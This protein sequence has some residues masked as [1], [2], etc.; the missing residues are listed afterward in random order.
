MKLNKF[1]IFSI[2]LVALAILTQA[3]NSN[4]QQNT[5]DSTLS[6]HSTSQDSSASDTTNNSKN[7]NPVNQFLQQAA[8]GGL[9]EIAMGEIGQQKASLKSIKDFAAMIEKDH[10]E[11]NAE[12]NALASAKGI[13]LPV[14]ITAMK[15]KHLKD[16]NETTGKDFD[17]YYINMMV[18]DHIDDIALFKGATKSPDMTIRAFAVKTLPVLQKHYKQA[19]EISMQFDQNK[20][21]K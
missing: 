1:K 10:T 8:T 7:I 13:K 4:H 2:S 11:A 3:C 5:A 9:V 16:L 6:N 19:R 15:K 17:S 14:E 12:L 18:E 21:K 20:N